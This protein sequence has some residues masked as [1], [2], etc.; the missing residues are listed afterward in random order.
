MGISTFNLS[1]SPSRLYQFGKNKDVRH[2]DHL[3]VSE[4]FL[5]APKPG[6]DQGSFPK[7]FDDPTVELH[8][9][10]K[11]LEGKYS[12]LERYYNKEVEGFD[13]SKWVNL[14]SDR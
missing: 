6:S 11:G 14:P 9:M 1:L 12:D 10:Q 2:A 3:L 5:S 7:V 4:S 13:W 8:I